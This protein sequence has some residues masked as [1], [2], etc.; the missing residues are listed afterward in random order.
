MQIKAT[1]RYYFTFIM[2]AKHF[3]KR[4]KITSVGEDV[5]KS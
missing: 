2:M 1:V 3:F 5:V 4:Q